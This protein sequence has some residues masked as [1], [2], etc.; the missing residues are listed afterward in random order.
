V[1]E[2][3][4]ISDVVGKTEQPFWIYFWQ[5][6]EVWRIDDQGLEKQFVFDTYKNLGQWLTGHPRPNSDCCWVGE[7]VVISPDGRKLA[8]IV[9]D[10]ID[11]S[12]KGES[13]T[14]SIFIYDT[15][16][17]EV[18]LL[19]EGVQPVWSPDSQRITYLNEGKL[20][21]GELDSG[22]V[23][24]IAEGD[25]SIPEHDIRRMAWSPDGNYISYLVTR[26]MM[27]PELKLINLLNPE[28]HRSLLP[29]TLYTIGNM[30]WS[31]D[32]QYLLYTSWEGEGSGPDHVDNL[33]TLSVADGSRKQITR[34]MTVM[35]FDLSPDGKWL[36]ISATIHYEREL[37]LYD[38][39]L[40]S[41]QGDQLIRVTKASPEDFLAYWSP[42]GTRL[43][44]YREG[45]GLVVF[46]LE[47]G[48]I[49]QLGIDPGSNF[50]IGGLK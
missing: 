12:T 19:G 13:F 50:A 45:S 28:T 8:L 37:Y 49:T 21:I 25:P 31:L 10:K 41:I 30:G 36:S 16:T 39:W 24:K 34:D 5:G 43:I 6:N 3:P 35:H 29:E 23:S 27:Y 15:L 9:V 7:R 48:T 44:F 42:D 46:S 20:W 47:K 26:S 14:F 40:A 33:W 38:I 2:P 4:V 11:I 22:Q 18:K 32:G 17:G 1:A